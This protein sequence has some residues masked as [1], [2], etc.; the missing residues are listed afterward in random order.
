MIGAKRYPSGAR[1]RQHEYEINPW[2]LG[3]YLSLLLW[4]AIGF[5]AWLIVS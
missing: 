1:L 5:I 4:I 2:A 3:I